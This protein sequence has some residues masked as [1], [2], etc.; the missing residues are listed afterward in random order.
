MT[1]WEPSFRYNR[2]GGRM[3]TQRLLTQV[4]ARWGSS[5]ERASDHR[6][7]ALIKKLPAIGIYWEGE[8]IPQ[9]SVNKYINHTPGHAHAQE[10]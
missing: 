5:T 9:W 1:P 3:D 10:F 6:L 4:Q 8:S 7:P 2:T